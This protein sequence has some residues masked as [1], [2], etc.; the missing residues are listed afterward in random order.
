MEPHDICDPTCER[1]GDNKYFDFANLHICAFPRSLKGPD[2][3]PV[4]VVVCP[5]V[6]CSFLGFSTLVL[7]PDIFSEDGAATFQ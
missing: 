5:Q 2:A 3:E 4:R 7:Y 6:I 1:Q